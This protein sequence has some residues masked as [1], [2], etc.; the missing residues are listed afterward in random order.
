[1]FVRVLRLTMSIFLPINL[2]VIL[3]TFGL[4]FTHFNIFSHDNNFIYIFLAKDYAQIFEQRILYI[5]LKFLC[6]YNLKS[7]SDLNGYINKF[8]NTIPFFYSAFHHFSSYIRNSICIIKMDHELP[9]CISYV[10]AILE[11]VVF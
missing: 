9:V 7:Y 5:M 1:M 8:H 6:I 11:I 10:K 2:Y 3:S 4:A